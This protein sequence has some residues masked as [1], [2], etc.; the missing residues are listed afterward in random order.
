MTALIDPGLRPLIRKLERLGPLSDEERR[1]LED[2]S[3]GARWV[4]A[5]RDLAREGERPTECQLIVKGLAC[6]YKVLDDGQ[7]QILSFQV[8]GDLLDLTALLLGRMDHGISTLTAVQVVL[9]PNAALLDWIGRYP[10][11][12]RLLWRDTLIDSEISCEWVA[13]VSARSASQRVAH[14]LCE[15]ATRLHAAGAARD[16]ACDLPLT[17][18]ELADA[19]GLSVVHVNRAVQTL[20]RQGLVEPRGQAMA[21]LDWAGLKRAA[22]FDPAYL[23]P[24]AAAA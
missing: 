3:P 17:P 15:L 22:D 18:M 14:L 19:T 9:V 5:A 24:L 8:P 23:H 6:R 12:G 7:R 16:H 10:N 13:K 11:L 20:R 4:G 21:A 2:F 1:T